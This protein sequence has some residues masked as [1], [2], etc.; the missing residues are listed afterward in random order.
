M[1]TLENEEHEVAERIRKLTLSAL[2]NCNV[3]GKLSDFMV[4]LTCLFPALF[5]WVLR[6]NPI[7]IYAK[8]RDNLFMQN[9][10]RSGKYNR[11]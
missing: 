1:A 5:T 3:F 10:A 7:V 2:E 11:W 9:R 8:Y 6:E 4:S